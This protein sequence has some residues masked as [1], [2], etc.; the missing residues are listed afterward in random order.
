[1]PALLGPCGAVAVDCRA[2]C[3]LHG[4]A[5]VSGRPRTA[6]GERRSERLCFQTPAPGHGDRMPCYSKV[7]GCR[8]IV[9]TALRWSN[10]PCRRLVTCKR[11]RSNYVAIMDTARGEGDRVRQACS[12]PVCRSRAA[13]AES[14][15]EP[16]SLDGFS[17]G[18]T[19]VSQGSRFPY[20]ARTSH[21][22]AK[23]IRA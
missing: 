20:L 6:E 17:R 2:C 18:F 5:T 10:R 16:R 11:E 21:C 19:G 12:G 13:G 8:S 9:C 14:W 1:M 4:P 7:N 15:M 3:P 22:A 23:L